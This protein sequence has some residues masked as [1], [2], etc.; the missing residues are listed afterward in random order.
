[1][2]ELFAIFEPEFMR[3]ALAAGLLLAPLTALLG[4]FVVLRGLSFFGEAIGHSTIAGVAVGL[5]LGL[6]PQD[7]T[8]LFLATL[9]GFSLLCAVAI[10]MLETRGALRTDTSI[11]IIYSSTIAMGNLLISSLASQNSSI[12]MVEVL[13]GSILFVQ[14]EEIASLAA[15]LA[16]VAL[17]LAKHRHQLTLMT[18][19]PEYAEAVGVPTRRLSLLFLLLL[20]MSV[21]VGVRMMGAILITA[22]LVIP[23]AAARNISATLRTMLL[24]G[25]VLSALSITGGMLLADRLD[26]P[27]GSTIVVLAFGIFLA[28]LA[29]AAKKRSQLPVEESV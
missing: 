8:G 4:C 16:L 28:S 17:F 10:H 12:T 9:V 19:H 5:L 21:A 6:S 26:A 27:A 15:L 22:L 2:A 7:D 13:F 29:W 24:A 3:R 14:M 11:A 1:M 18:L 23:A 20:T 25:C